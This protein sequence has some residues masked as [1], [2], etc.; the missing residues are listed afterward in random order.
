MSK[1]NHQKIKINK[2]EQKKSNKQYELSH[3]KKSHETS[4]DFG[5]DSSEE[6]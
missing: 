1:D 2:K 6:D 3:R 4:S 5:Y